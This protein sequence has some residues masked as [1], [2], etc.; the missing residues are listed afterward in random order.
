MVCHH[1]DKFCDHSYCDSGAIMFLMFLQL[2]MGT[3]LKC[4]VNTLVDAPHDKSNTL[5]C[6]VVIGLLQVEI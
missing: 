1:P 2:H 4:Y 3:S 5:S 6:L